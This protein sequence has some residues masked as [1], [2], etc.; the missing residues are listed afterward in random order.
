MMKY[1]AIGTLILKILGGIALLIGSISTLGRDSDALNSLLL[2]TLKFYT[3]F[4]EV[5]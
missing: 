5:F 1:D 4:I 3:D 2:Y